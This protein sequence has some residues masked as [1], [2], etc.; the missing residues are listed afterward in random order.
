MS[1]QLPHAERLAQWLH[2]TYV[3]V[4]PKHDYEIR[5]AMAVAWPDLPASN[6]D[7]MTEVMQRFIDTYGP[8]LAVARVVW[9][10]AGSVWADWSV[11]RIDP[12][13]ME[14]LRLALIKYGEITGDQRPTD[15]LM[16]PYEESAALV[17]RAVHGGKVDMSL[18]ERI[19]ALGAHRAEDQRAGH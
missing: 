9:D 1:H 8:T 17:A 19:L 18:V 16:R 11:G 14:Y 10:A 12:S 7:L 6:R 15:P 4:A 2:E 5:E 3:S 13:N